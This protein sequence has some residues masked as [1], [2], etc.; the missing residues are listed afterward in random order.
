MRVVWSVRARADLDHIR[1]YIARDNPK[2]AER[3]AG[4]I[5]ATVE[6]LIDNPRMGH[7]GAELGTFEIVA[8]PYVIVYELYRDRV[9]IIGIWHGAQRRPGT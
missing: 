5:L 7:A 2:A 6:G 3:M 8:R 1:R 4:S 9:S